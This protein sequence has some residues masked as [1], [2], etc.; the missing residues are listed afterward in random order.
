MRRGTTPTLTCTVN[1]ADLS[2]TTFYVTIEQD[3]VELNIKNPDCKT[4]E[5][6]CEITVVLTQEQTLQLR[7]GRAQIQIRW[8]DENGTASA[9]P[10]KTLDVE[11]ILKEGE[12]SYE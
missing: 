8:I 5:T 9:T 7:S 3:E 1:G 6:G 2:S 11:K 12:I 4:T 10:V